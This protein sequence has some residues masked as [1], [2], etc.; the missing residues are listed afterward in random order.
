MSEAVLNKV[1]EITAEVLKIDAGTIEEKSH[2]AN[3]LGADSVQSIELVAAFCEGFDI[4][5]DEEEALNV[6]N[7]GDA[8]AFIA[9][10]CQE[11]GK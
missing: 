9:K 6:S 2:F 4:E 11:Q 8:V 7:V 5:M 3:D 10:C 1:K